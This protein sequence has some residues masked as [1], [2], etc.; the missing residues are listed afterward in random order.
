MDGSVRFIQT[1]VNYL[2]WYAIST[3]RGSEVISGDA[4]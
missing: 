1:S 2:T 3:P 4:L